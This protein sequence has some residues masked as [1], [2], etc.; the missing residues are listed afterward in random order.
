MSARA[1]WVI[2]VLAPVS[3]S[4][5]P[6]TRA[7]SSEARSEPV[8]GSVNTAVGRISRRGDWQQYCL[9]RLGAAEPD[10]LGGDLRA[11]AERA[12]ADI[13][14][15]QLLGDHAHGQ[16]AQAEPAPL[17]GHGQA[18][19]AELGQL[20]D[21]R[22]RDQFVAQVP[23]VGDGRTSS[24]T[25]RRNWRRTSSRPRRPGPGRR[26]R[27]RGSSSARRGGRRGRRALDQRDHGLGRMSSAA[28][29]RPRSAGAHDLDLADRD[30]AGNAGRDIRRTP[31]WSALS[32]SSVALRHPLRPAPHLAQAAT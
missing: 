21:H 6:R 1:A 30:A 10:Q 11:R 22:Q 23:A 19:H 20:L 32:S 17:L 16:L 25:K 3:C 5:R 7:W 18:E 12:D 24:S 26:T 13:A 31:T 14:A 8:L 2:Q 27:R 28:A 9:L 15:R 29:S 4:G